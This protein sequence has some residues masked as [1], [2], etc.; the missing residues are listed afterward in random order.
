MEAKA[1][2]E[3]RL[4]VQHISTFLFF[5]DIVLAFQYIN[6]TIYKNLSKTCLDLSKSKYRNS[7]NLDYFWF[8]DYF[9]KFSENWRIC[10]LNLVLEGNI[11]LST[12]FKH[13]F[14]KKTA[15]FLNRLKIKDDREEDSL[16][17]EKEENLL[18]Y[19]LKD[20]KNINKLIIKNSAILFIWLPLEDSVFEEVS[21][22]LAKIE[23][24]EI[25]MFLGKSILQIPESNDN[26]L[27]QMKK[28]DLSLFSSLENFILNFSYIKR[29]DFLSPATSLVNLEITHCPKLKSLNG[30]EHLVKLKKLNISHCRSLEDTESL[31]ELSGLRSFSIFHCEKVTSLPLGNPSFLNDVTIDT[32]SVSS[33]KFL[34][35]CKQLQ[36]LSVA[37]CPFEEENEHLI[38]IEKGS[39]TYF[40]PPIPRFRF[41]YELVLTE[42][43]EVVDLSFGSSGN[44]NRLKKLEIKKCNNL[45]SFQGL[46]QLKNLEDLFIA[47]CPNLH[48]IQEIADSPQ[49]KVLT[50]R[51]VN[52]CITREFLSEKQLKSTNIETLNVSF[53][54]L[55][56]TVDDLNFLPNL[57]SLFFDSCYFLTDIKSLAK[58]QTIKNLKLKN[59]NNVE[60]VSE[61]DVVSETLETLEILYCST[62]TTLCLARSKVYNL[63]SVKFQVLFSWRN[64]DE[65]LLLNNL[66]NLEL[67]D[68]WKLENDIISE[69]IIEKMKAMQNLSIIGTNLDSPEEL[70]GREGYIFKPLEHLFQIPQFEL[71]PKI[72]FIDNI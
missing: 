8:V 48:D 6:K 32:V 23:H 60:M 2:F 21:S 11:S 13:H 46:S 65:L 35:V 63:T 61:F 28:I 31:S 53:V 15:K 20:F 72:E 45:L 62:F 49:V 54:I 44:L 40:P 43:P 9:Q 25:I 12:F 19:G 30:L 39:F 52:V 68:C 47:S 7:Q 17:S 66:Q 34:F 57:K 18:L 16:I 42:C 36:T 59:L 41:L 1:V 37:F 51:R 26:F 3:D 29:L 71:D 10:S 69:D 4:L 70:T 58:N 50:L 55:L 5:E 27:A 22:S 56:E 33:F 14:N 67:L 64:L 38:E 24:L